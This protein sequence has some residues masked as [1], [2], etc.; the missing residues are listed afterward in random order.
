[1]TGR[2]VALFRGI[3]VGRAKRVVMADLREL[4]EDLGY[5]DVRTLARSGNVVFT[6]PGTSAGDAGGR[7]A[8]ALVAQ[9]GISSRVTVLTAEE[10]ATAVAGNPLLGI[11]DE[12]SR[13]L[14]TFL[15]SAADRARVEP[16]ASRRWDPEAF[17]L[18]ERVAYL[19]CPNGVLASRVGEAVARAVDD[20][21][22]TR[23]WSTVTKL[24][25]LVL[26]KR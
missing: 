24:L 12:P 15:A 2:H 4:V 17:A 5:A 20:T 8:A 9:L 7:I 13:L 14:V 3:N 1:M 6:A 11:A 16:L 26:S 10:L 19:W 21:A 18:G 22:T 23:N 25:A